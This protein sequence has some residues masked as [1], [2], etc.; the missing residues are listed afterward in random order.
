MATGQKLPVQ[1]KIDSKRLIQ[2]RDKNQLTIP[3]EVTDQLNVKPGDFLAFELVED[4]LKLTPVHVAITVKPVPTTSY[5]KAKLEKANAEDHDHPEYS[6]AR[7]LL[8][9]LKKDKK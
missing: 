8:G 3:K 6:D 9:H 1:Q 5:W 4:G 7:Q 2:L